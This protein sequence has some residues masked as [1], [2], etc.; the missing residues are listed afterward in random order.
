[1]AWLELSTG[2]NS[3]IVTLA[4]GSVYTG[5]MLILS[6][7]VSVSVLP[8]AV[9]AFGSRSLLSPYLSFLVIP[10]V[11]LAGVLWYLYQRTSVGWKILAVG[12][13]ETAPASAGSGRAGWSSSASRSPASSAVSRRS[14]RCRVSPLP[15]PRS[16][17][18]G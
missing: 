7:G 8:P 15:F 6:K 16:G 14:W 13:N 10:A 5:L 12:G 4:M 3:F 2:L 18:R 11:V 1:M 9:T 17:R